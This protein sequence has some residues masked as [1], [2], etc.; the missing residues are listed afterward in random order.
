MSAEISRVRWPA[1][2]SARPSRI[3]TVLLPSACSAL[4]TS[5]TCGP[6]AGV[7]LKRIDVASVW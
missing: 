1:W 5:T 2:A 7:R 3:V 4:V 6:S